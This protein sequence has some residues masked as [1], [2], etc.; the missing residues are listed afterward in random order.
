MISQGIFEPRE[1]RSD[2]LNLGEIYRNQGYSELPLGEWGMLMFRF[3][4]IDGRN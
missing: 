1:M 3:R 2:A 4:L